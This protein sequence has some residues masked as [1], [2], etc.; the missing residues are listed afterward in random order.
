[1]V[2]FTTAALV[3]ALTLSGCASI[4]TNYDPATLAQLTPGMT[5]AEV[6]SRMGA[7]NSRTIMQDGSTSLMWLHSSANAFGSGSGKS[8]VILIDK[9][10]RFV[11]VL[12]T[13]ETK[14]N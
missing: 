12:T 9:D 5:E 11:R 1:M 6:V 14:L 8:A 3:A 4:G 7:P 2:R 10:G 13:T